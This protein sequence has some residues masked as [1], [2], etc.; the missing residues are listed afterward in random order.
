M[1]VL[2]IE[3]SGLDFNKC[4][5]W[6][7]GAVE[8]ENPHNVFLQEARIDDE[9]IVQEG[10]LRVTGTT[11]E[12]LRDPS[13]QSQKQLL[14]SF[15]KWCENIR[16]RNCICQGPQWDLGFIWIKASK[17]RLREKLDNPIPHRAFDMHSIAALKYFQLNG[18]FLLNENK[19]NMGL[20][21]ILKFVGMVDNRGAHNA[22]EDAKLTAECFSRVVFGRNLLLEYKEYP[23]PEYLKGDKENDNL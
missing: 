20:S 1:I 6:Q 22:L 3:T 5:I 14:E 11:E 2:D 21:N 23:V 15:F 17:Y 19:S 4:G 13:K 7:I 9:N 10:A 8:L 12:Q 18:K 16:V